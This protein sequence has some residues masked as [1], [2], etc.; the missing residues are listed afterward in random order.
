MSS[1]AIPD[2]VRRP[3]DAVSAASV[4]AGA[5][6]FSKFPEANTRDVVLVE[7]AGNFRV[8]QTHGVMRT[9]V[10]VHGIV[11]T[12]FLPFEHWVGEDLAHAGRQLWVSSKKTSRVRL[13][14]G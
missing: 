2:V 10:R 13:G 11:A 6:E 1:V 7:E 3:S 8:D 4:S 14:H 5:L 12:Q 9:Y